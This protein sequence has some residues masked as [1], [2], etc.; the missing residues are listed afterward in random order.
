MAGRKFLLC[1]VIAL[2][3]VFVN[4]NSG[5]YD[6][7][8]NGT[9]A[10]VEG[11]IEVGYK[12]RNGN[13]E[14]LLYNESQIKGNYT[15]ENGEITMKWTNILGDLLYRWYRIDID[16]KMYTEAEFYTAIKPVLVEMELD[17]ER[18]FEIFNSTI[19]TI[20]AVDPSPYSIEENALT[21]MILDTPIKLTKVQ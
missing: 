3:F 14:L 1:L 21:I 17:E 16:P 10:L 5:K 20:V 9:W 15:T 7:D 19:M 13:F 11:G 2:G 4:C 8:L 12:F 6:K 18:F